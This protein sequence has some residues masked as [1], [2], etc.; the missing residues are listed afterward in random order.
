MY[1]QKLLYALKIMSPY[2]IFA[3]TLLNIIMA[4]L[5]QII[6]NILSL[7]LYRT[8]DMNQRPWIKLEVIVEELLNL[9]NKKIMMLMGE[10]MF[11]LRVEMHILDY[12][13]I[14]KVFKISGSGA[15]K[16]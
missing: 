5:Y 1:S 9:Q 12:P 8:S 3:F 7:N 11:S 16:G 2:M 14:G 6:I 13:G 10:Q 15:Y 4:S